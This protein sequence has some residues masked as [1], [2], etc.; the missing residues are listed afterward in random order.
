MSAAKTKGA[1]Q[2]RAALKI[3]LA[4]SPK[5]KVHIDFLWPLPRTD[6]GHENILIMVDTSQGIECVQFP[7]QTV[8][9][10]KEL[11][12][13][14]GFGY[15]YKL[16]KDQVKHFESEPI[17]KMC[18]TQWIYKTQTTLYKPSGNGKVE[19]YYGTLIHAVPCY[20]DDCP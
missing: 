5:E 9:V 20:I 14:S 11:P 10:N 16:F 1:L 3:Y 4:G 15:P 19:H 18:E 2:I 17:F 6:N 7:S 12:S 8:K 13:F